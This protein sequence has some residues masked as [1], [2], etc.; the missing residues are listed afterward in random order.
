MLMK[1]SRQDLI[2]RERKKGI[3][4]WKWFLIKLGA[5]GLVKAVK[6]LF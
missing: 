4:F 5:E 2:Y 3:K 6:D 1:K